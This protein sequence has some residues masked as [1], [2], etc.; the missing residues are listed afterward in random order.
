MK[1]EIKLVDKEKGIIQVTTCDERWYDIEKKGKDGKVA[2][3]FIPSVTWIAS[4]YPK[5]TE[6]YKWLA[7]HGWDESQ[8][9]MHEA[10]NRGSKVHQ[11]I[12][13]LVAGVELKADE[14]F[15]NP[16]T[17][18]PEEL[19]VEEWEAL[20]SFNDWVKTTKP[21]FIQNEQTVIS[22]EHNFAGTVDCVAIINGEYYIIDW[23]TSQYIWPSMEIQISAY[24]HA[25]PKIKNAKLAVL[26]VG[27][28]RNKRG[29]KFTEIEDKFDL[30]KSAQAIWKNENDNKK[31]RQRDL[32]LTLKLN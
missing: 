17:G 11:A 25:M 7:K 4:Y 9:I 29:W 6:F 31:P 12:E 8:A 20:C 18:Q 2:Y 21:Q 24:K 10:G 22:K 14:H 1:K 16:N 23:K 19:S 3:D 15:P 27:Y 5:G 26:Q 28:K 13:A 32:P 30:F